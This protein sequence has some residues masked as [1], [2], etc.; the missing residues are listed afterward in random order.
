MSVDALTHDPL[1]IQGG[2][3]CWPPN[4]W[5][6]VGI[7]SPTNI[8]IFGGP[9]CLNSAK[10]IDLN[11]CTVEKNDSYRGL[12]PLGPI[13]TLVLALFHMFCAAM[14]HEPPSM[15]PPILPIFLHLCMVETN[16]LLL[17]YRFYTYGNFP[18]EDHLEYIEKEALQKFGSIDPGTE[19]PV[20][21]LW[22]SPVSVMVI[23]RGWRKRDLDHGYW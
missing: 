11:Q 14:Y 8:P 7:W 21:S 23:F 17:S 18:L 5:T 12:C 10:Y 13:M 9:F 2:R 20:E 16:Q 4:I 15:P 1:D 19:V 6:G 22:T 3:G